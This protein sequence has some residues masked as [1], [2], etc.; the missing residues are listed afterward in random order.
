MIDV[1]SIKNGMTLLIEGNIYQI[2][3]FLENNIDYF[4]F[5]DFYKIYEESECE[6]FSEKEFLNIFLKN[7]SNHQ[8]KSRLDKI[9]NADGV[10][11]PHEVP[12]A[13]LVESSVPVICQH[14]RMDVTQ[15]EMTLMT[16]IAY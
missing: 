7:L 12:Y 8:L 14:S 15:A 2:V 3:E 13:I 16:T 9:K 10:A 6:I 11:I 5:E 1:N 4:L